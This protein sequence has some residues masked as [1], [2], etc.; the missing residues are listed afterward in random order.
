MLRILEDAAQFLMVLHK[1]VYV[2]NAPG[3]KKLK[4][5]PKRKRGLKRVRIFQA[6][7]KE[8]SLEEPST[9]HSVP[10]PKK[11]K[12]AQASWPE[13]NADLPMSYVSAAKEPQRA[14]KEESPAELSV[15]CPRRRRPTK[16][17]QSEKWV[18]S[19]SATNDEAFI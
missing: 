16:D 9:E 12:C 10:R 17:N 2:V 4:W 19:H 1:S 13:T 11:R 14:S 6:V 8:E 15:S 5:H 3:A 18:D 7:I